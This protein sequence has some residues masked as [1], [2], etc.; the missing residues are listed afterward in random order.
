LRATASKADLEAKI[1]RSKVKLQI[2]TAESRAQAQIQKTERIISYVFTDK[3]IL[4]EA[5]LFKK[6]EVCQFGK[7]YITMKNM[8]L[9]ILGNSILH[10]AIVEDKF[11][12]GW[13]TRTNPFYFL[14][15]KRSCLLRSLR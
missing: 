6:A 10:S 8:R 7:R 14:Q 13:S 15:S 4:L 2:S 11:A 1:A 12:K 3:D 9:A 5:L